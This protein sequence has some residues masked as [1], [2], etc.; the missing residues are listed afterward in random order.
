[1]SL[2]PFRSCIILFIDTHASPFGSFIIIK[3]S[4]QVWSFCFLFRETLRER[5]RER[6]KGRETD[7]KTELHRKND[8]ETDS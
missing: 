4:S 5:E 3:L 8:S 6:E 1:M 7:R 2:F